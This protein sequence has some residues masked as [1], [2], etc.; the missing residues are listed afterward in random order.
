MIL[1]WEILNDVYSAESLIRGAL[2]MEYDKEVDERDFR[3]KD[4]ILCVEVF[5]IDSRLYDQNLD[6]KKFKDTDKI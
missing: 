6:N 2:P 1:S 3:T 4:G 5:H